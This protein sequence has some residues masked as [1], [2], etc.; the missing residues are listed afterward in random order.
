MSTSICVESLSGSESGSRQPICVPFT[1][2]PGVTLVLAGNSYG[3]SVIAKIIYNMFVFADLGKYLVGE[4]RVEVEKDKRVA[5]AR[6]RVHNRD[7]INDLADNL[8]LFAPGSDDRYSGLGILVDEDVS[9][10]AARSMDV[11]VRYPEPPTAFLSNMVG[12]A[13]RAVDLV[14]T[15]DERRRSIKGLLE[16]KRRILDAYSSPSGA[17]RVIKESRVDEK[18]ARK[19][20]EDL[21]RRADELRARRAELESRLAAVSSSEIAVISSEM[22]KKK[23]RLEQLMNEKNMVEGKIS[24]IASKLGIAVNYDRLGEFVDR[25]EAIR[26]EINSRLKE[27]SEKIATAE[28]IRSN[29][30][31]VVDTVSE[32][33]GSVDIDE[34]AKTVKLPSAMHTLNMFRDKIKNLLDI[35]RYAD[36]AKIVENIKRGVDNAVSLCTGYSVLCDGF[37]IL[38]NLVVAVEPNMASTQIRTDDLDDA[39]NKLRVVLN[40]LEAAL[41]RYGQE[42]YSKIYR[43]LITIKREA[44]VALSRIDEEAKKLAEEKARLEDSRVDDDVASLVDRYS[45]LVSEIKAL[46]RDIRDLEERYIKALSEAGSG[47]ERIVRE[48]ESINEQLKDIERQIKETKEKIPARSDE[49]A[50]TA[51]DLES[52]ESQL[53]GCNTIFDMFYDKLLSRYIEKNVYMVV[54]PSVMSTSTYFSYMV[55]VSAAFNYLLNRFFSDYIRMRWGREGSVP[56]VVDIPAAYDRNHLRTLVEL[57]Y[58][59]AVENG[60]RVYLFYVHDKHLVININS[61]EDLEVVLKN[62]L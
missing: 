28:A 19:V 1:T 18:A 4:H 44:E 31:N 53:D 15:D 21:E 38:A 26:S 14:E 35:K 46:E 22:E 20:L 55:A 40:S 7:E 3:K 12:T 13:L 2:D 57:L 56:L 36:A 37:D 9:R 42:L 6:I 25:V 58:R 41:E 33:L 51:E 43:D 52:F 30:K 59:Y 54:S 60:V 17:R 8:L 34:K 11:L 27:L 16:K 5:T 48:I 32:A 29:I 39:I 45:S 24:S 50:V 47:R 23:K 61:K 62:I 10:H 49:D